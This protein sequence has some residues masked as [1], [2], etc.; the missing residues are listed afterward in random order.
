MAVGYLASCP[1]KPQRRG[2]VAIGNDDRTAGL[3]RRDDGR[4]KLC[5]VRGRGSGLLEA[6]GRVDD[7][8]PCALRVAAVMTRRPGLQLRFDALE[9]Q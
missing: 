2:S 1:R 3:E 8:R 7:A 9:H 4:I 6:R 5:R